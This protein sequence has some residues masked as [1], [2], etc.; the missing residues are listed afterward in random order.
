MNDPYSNLFQIKSKPF[1]EIKKNSEAK[2]V[3]YNQQRSKILNIYF[4]GGKL[5]YVAGSSLHVY[6]I[7]NRRSNQLVD[8]EEDITQLYFFDMGML[9]IESYQSYSFEVIL[10]FSVDLTFN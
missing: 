10:N 9:A 4:S 1:V 3:T 5:Y 2:L 6:S 8:L 7:A